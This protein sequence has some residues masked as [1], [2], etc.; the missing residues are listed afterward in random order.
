MR[1]VFVA[2]SLLI[3]VLPAASAVTRADRN[4]LEPEGCQAFNPGQPK[5]SYEV[6]HETDSPV[7]GVAGAGDW[8]VKIKRGKG[9]KK[10]VEKIRSSSS[11]GEPTAVE[12][13]FEAGDK[14]TAKALSPGSGLIVGHAD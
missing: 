9:K 3:S 8:I 4:A 14:V 6:T 11:Y 13:Q 2:V 5:C 7:T 10:Q 12:F 1:H